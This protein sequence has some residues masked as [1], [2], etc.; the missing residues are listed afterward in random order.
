MAEEEAAAKN[1]LNNEKDQVLSK[2]RLTLLSDPNE[3]CDDPEHGDV[4]EIVEGSLLFLSILVFGS[5]AHNDNILIFSN[6]GSGSI[7]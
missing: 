5:R 1:Q 6:D 2:R 3:F 4:D 7:Q